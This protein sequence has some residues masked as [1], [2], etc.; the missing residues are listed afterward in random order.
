MTDLREIYRRGDI[1]KVIADSS[2][3]GVNH[4]GIE[5][6]REGTIR[7]VSSLDVTVAFTDIESQESRVIYFL[8]KEIELVSKRK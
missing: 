4:H 3:V 5:L 2:E 6:G 7:G 8:E 1:V